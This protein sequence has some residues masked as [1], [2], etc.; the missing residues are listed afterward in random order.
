MMARSGVAMAGTGGRRERAAEVVE[1]AT[2]D[3]ADARFAE[4][5][6][7]FGVAR[8]WRKIRVDEPRVGR[9]VLSRRT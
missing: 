8:G 9:F 1:I 7:A 3:Q 2:Q 4:A 6:G 5:F